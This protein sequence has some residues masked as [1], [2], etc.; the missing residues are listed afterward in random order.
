MNDVVLIELPTKTAAERLLAA[1]RPQRFAWLQGCKATAHVG[2][3]LSTEADDLAHL[4]LSV[5]AWL[6]RSDLASLLFELDGRT[7][8]LEPHRAQ[9]AA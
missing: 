6:Q 9:T 8:L 3:L 4:L 1:L 7:Y 2:T 5:Q